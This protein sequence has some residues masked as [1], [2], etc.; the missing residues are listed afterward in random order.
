MAELVPVAF[1]VLLRRARREFDRREAIFDLP[2]RK[3]YRP[4]PA[5]DLSVPYAG[6]R[7]AN[8]IG[9]AAGPHTQLAQNI[10]LC[11]LAGARIIE[12]KTVQANDTLTL[13]RPC[14]DMATLGYNTEW[15]QELRLD[16]S[17]REYV[18]A[19]MLIQAL[20]AWGVLGSPGQAD[21][22]VFD[23]SV[24]YDLAGIR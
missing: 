24:G 6:E 1:P 23:I 4:S 20:D 12:L 7:A 5:T 9:P 2:A 8:P 10:A 22:T 18:K 11:W 21:G 13:S 19:S 14:I 3:F 17:V 15:S 16:L